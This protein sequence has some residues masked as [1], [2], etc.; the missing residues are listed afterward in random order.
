M[1]APPDFRVER[2]AKVQVFYQRE[3]LNAILRRHVRDSDA[4]L[5][6]HQFVKEIARRYLKARKDVLI[7]PNE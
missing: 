2:L 7:D 6:D 1:S 3:R 5:T 4:A